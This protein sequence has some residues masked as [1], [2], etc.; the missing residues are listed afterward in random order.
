MRYPVILAGALAM[1]GTAASSPAVEMVKVNCADAAALAAGLD[2]VGAA[3]A[4]AIVAHRAN[5]PFKSADDLAAVKGIGEK[6]V[7]TNRDRIDVTEDCGA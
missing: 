6:T 2:G 3:K 1:L 4:E 7:E 5:A